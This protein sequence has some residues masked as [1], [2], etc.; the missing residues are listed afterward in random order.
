MDKQM[1][2]DRLKRFKKLARLGS[3]VYTKVNPADFRLLDS[4][5]GHYSN[6]IV[7]SIVFEADG[8]QTYRHFLLDKRE[9][10]FTKPVRTAEGRTFTLVGERANNGWYSIEIFWGR[11]S[12]GERQGRSDHDAKGTYF[13]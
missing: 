6:G 1:A 8:M 11:H 7:L 9:L 10:E 2:R 3:Y 4:H 12:V 13:E 5:L